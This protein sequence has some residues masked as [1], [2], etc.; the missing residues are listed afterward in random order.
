[1]PAADGSFYSTAGYGG[2]TNASY[3]G[4]GYGTVFQLTTNGTVAVPVV[5]GNTNG[6]YPAGGLVRGQD[7]NFYGT[8]TWGGRGITGILP[9]LRHSIQD[10]S[11]RNV[12]QHL[13]VHRV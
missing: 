4:H 13:P 10:D 5:F 3:Y 12:H 1:M 7:G 8:T 9:R 2:L 11:R 6:A